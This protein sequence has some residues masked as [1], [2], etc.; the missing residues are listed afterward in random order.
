MYA[1]AT[2]T[3]TIA[4]LPYKS[5]FS[6][7]LGYGPSGLA[8]HKIPPALYATQWYLGRIVKFD[9][10]GAVLGQYG[11]P[12]NNNGE[13]VYTNGI[14]TDIAG[15]IFVCDCGNNRVQEFDASGS[16][17][18]TWGG[19][20]SGNGDG[21]FYNPEGIAIDS[22]GNVYV[23]D[24][25]NRRVQKFDSS[26]NFILKWG[27]EGTNDGQFSD[28][29]GIAMDSTDNV[30]IVDS[31]GS[32]VQ[33]FSKTGVFE[34]K[35]GGYGSGNGQFYNPQGIAVAANGEIYVADSTNNRIQKFTSAGAYIT[36]WG[37]SYN[38]PGSG[39]GEFDDPQ[40]L[41]F[42]A[43]GNLYVADYN[44]HRVQVFGK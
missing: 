27:S 15:N 32:R 14:T 25:G 35:F 18:A 37:N 17:L 16:W 8:I 3:A 42:D 38:N 9:L 28:T 29:I 40:G 44:N 21:Q 43:A 33:K 23:T 12:G 30:Y 39:D 2:K 19:T 22:S 11:T 13:F 5:Q 41:A 24:E 6:F 26:G 4:A 1:A 36:Q 20:A 34:M 7:P 10:S 31:M